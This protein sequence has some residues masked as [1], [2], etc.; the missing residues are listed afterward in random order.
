MFPFKFIPDTQTN[1]ITLITLK[2]SYK[3]DGLTY[4]IGSIIFYVI[5]HQSII[6]TDD[7]LRYDFLINKIDEIFNSSRFIGIGKM[8]FYDMDEIVIDSS[9]KWIGSYIM[10]K[11]TEFQ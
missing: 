6:S 2:C 1:P 9:G 8:P 3:P 7:G 5:T 4:K 11:T 10:Y